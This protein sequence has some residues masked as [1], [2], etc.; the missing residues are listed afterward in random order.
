MNNPLIVRREH[1][2]AILGVAFV[3]AASTMIWQ[4][5]VTV[6][7]LDAL[8]AGEASRFI[9]VKPQVDIEKQP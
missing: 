7:E 3:L 4:W 5:F 2:F 6:H 8:A 1:G 9:S